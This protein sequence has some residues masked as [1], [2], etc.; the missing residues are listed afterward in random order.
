[1]AV[2]AAFNAS[3]KQPS[4]I[5]ACA[6]FF[7]RAMCTSRNHFLASWSYSGALIRH[8]A[9]WPRRQLARASWW[10]PFSHASTPSLLHRSPKRT[11]STSS[12]GSSRACPP[13]S[14][15]FW[16]WLLASSTSCCVL[17]ESHSLKSSSAPRSPCKSMVSRNWQSELRFSCLSINSSKGTSFSRD[18][19][20]ACM[21]NTSTIL[22]FR[23]GWTRR[24]ASTEQSSSASATC[25][26]YRFSSRTLSNC[27]SHVFFRPFQCSSVCSSALA[28]GFRAT[29]SQN[30]GSFESRKKFG[31]KRGSSS[32]FLHC[33]FSHSGLSKLESYAGY[34]H[35]FSCSLV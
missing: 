7:N 11:R 1:M 4:L 6:R 16:S 3:L 32:S 31:F 34:C 18:S 17:L 23:I 35:S 28:Q 12:S 2:S 24:F 27:C 15:S 19:L 21:R 25:S 26:R 33:S 29:F 10:L 9:S 13:R 14:L 20:S 8:R 22:Y 30:S 5:A